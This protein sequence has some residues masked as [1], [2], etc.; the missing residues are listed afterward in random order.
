MGTEAPRI[1]SWSF[2]VMFKRGK[3]DH[4]TALSMM[5]RTPFGE[6]CFWSGLADDLFIKD[7]QPHHTAEAARHIIL[8]DTASLDATVAE[9]RCKQN[10]RKLETVHEGSNL[11]AAVR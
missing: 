6:Q 10:L 2:D 11:K 9:D 8:I 3:L 4:Q 5:P 1:F 7:E